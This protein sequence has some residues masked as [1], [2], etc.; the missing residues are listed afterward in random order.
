MTSERYLAV[1]AM[2]AGA[3]HD[4][5]IQMRY[6]PEHDSITPTIDEIHLATV[7]VDLIVC[8]L[9]AKHEQIASAVR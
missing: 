6:R 2:V 4:R 8:P 3:L 5:N 9:A 1:V 7:L